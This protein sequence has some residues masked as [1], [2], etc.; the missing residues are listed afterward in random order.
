MIDDL[1][2]IERD[3]RRM[4]L[5]H[6]LDPRAK[7]LV[8]FGA[9]VAVVAF[10]YSEEVY[11][12]ALPFLLF[13]GILWIYSG[14]SMKTYAHRV[15]LTLPFGFFIIFFQIFFENTRYGTVTPLISLPLGI[16][17][18]RE[19]ALFAS[20]LGVKFLLCISFI[21]LLSSTTTMENLLKGARSLGLPSVMAISLGLMIRYLF[22]FTGMLR[23]VQ[24]SL[25]AR[26]FNAFNRSL[27]YIYRLRIMGYAIGMLF[28][29]SY[30]QGERTYAGML[31]RGYAK[32][33]YEYLSPRPFTRADWSFMIG[34]L[35]IVVAV[36][37]S[38][39]LL[40]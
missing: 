26:N 32:D 8:C 30:E 34:S 1:F 36:P 19:S 37:V 3:A 38:V 23:Q 35:F 2:A 20:I 29:R 22:V 12:L 21:I 39:F 31:C 25:A 40:A 10:P 4:S 11:L 6:G 24:A 27:P 33:A 16:T 17:V 15:L 28:I 14:L 9:I 5:V 7:L 18:Y 13:F